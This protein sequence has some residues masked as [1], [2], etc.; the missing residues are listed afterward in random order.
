MK[1]LCLVLVLVSV[2][3]SSAAD[4]CDA[5][6]LPCKKLAILDLVAKWNADECE[7]KYDGYHPMEA[8]KLMRS[9]QQIKTNDKT[10]Q[11]GLYTL[12]TE[13]GVEYQTYC[14]MTT[15]G[16][17]WTLV[18]SVHENNM[19]GKCTTGDRWSSQQGSNPNLP[20]GDDN[21]ANYNTFGTAS[22]ATSDDYKNPGYYDIKAKDL[23]V[24][25]V[26]NVTPIKDWRNDALLR[27][28][29][30]NG[31]L[32]AEGGNLF[33]LFQKYP[34]RFGIASCPSGNGPAVPIVFDKGN[35]QKVIDYYSPNGRGQFTAG[36]VQFRV[37]N[38]E[39]AA[40]A[41]CPGMKVHGCDTEHHCIGGGGHFPEA[42]PKQCGD[43]ASYD[44]DGY[45]ASAGSSASKAIT[46]AA[47]LLWYR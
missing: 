34:V 2:S 10:S 8:M 6:D 11:D 1:I 29:T 12:V 45:G 23:A 37:M 7:Q 44:W 13:D 38:N 30:E 19:Y 4:E 5:N 16:G 21:W 46:E 36:Y 15:N 47:V 9:C 43:F 33:Q 20:Q 32:P 14:D 22:G 26:P 3:W 27:Y 35:A 31:F 41:L 40:L 39:K 42:S 24:W 17:G 28:R 18:A 25:H